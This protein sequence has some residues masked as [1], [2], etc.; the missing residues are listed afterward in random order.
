[1]GSDTFSVPSLEVCLAKADVLAVYTQPDRPAGRGRKRLL[2]TPVRELAAEKGLRIEQP[3]RFDKQNC[4]TLRGFGADLTVVAA[5]GA[6]LP[7]AALATARVDSIN[8]HASLLPRHR[9]A[10]AVAAAI[11]VGDSRAGVTVMKLRPELDAGEIICIAERGR[12]QA[13]TPIRDD[14][15]TGSL[16]ARLATMGG[17]LLAD[18]LTAYADRSVTYEAQDETLATYAPML[19]KA[20]GRIDW[21]RS[22]EQVVRHVRAMTP[23]PGAFS[24]LHSSEGPAMRIIVLAVRAQSECPGGTPGDVTVPDG[25]RLLV[26]A[27]QGCVE[28][29]ELKPAGR[30]AM[31]AAEFLLGR[32]VV[33]NAQKP[34]GGCRFGPA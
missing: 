3:E 22:A 6:L 25:S 15:T 16:T 27:G 14:D 33:R 11:L 8:V 26:T 18:V 7:K 31:R 4:E 12:A 19:S 23:W 17:D 29:V 21:S 30:N 13:A 20:D 28:L 9:G 2:C 32:N 24:E 1:M 34:G 10:A 5:H